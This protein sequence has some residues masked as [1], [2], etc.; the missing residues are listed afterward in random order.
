MS[1]GSKIWK[2]YQTAKIF[3]FQN[4]NEINNDLD[5]WKLVVDSQFMIVCVT[6]LPHILVILFGY[7]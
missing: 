1:K 7:L 3:L 6:L 5:V 4:C 2:I